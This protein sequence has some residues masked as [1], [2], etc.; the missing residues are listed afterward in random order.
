ML[1]KLVFFCYTSILWFTSSY[2]WTTKHFPCYS[3]CFVLEIVSSLSIKRIL[4]SS[5]VYDISLWKFTMPRQDLTSFL[6]VGVAIFE[7]ASIFLVRGWIPFLV[8]QIPK[9]SNSALQTLILDT[10][11]FKPASLS[12]EKIVLMCSMFPLN[13]N[14]WAFHILTQIYTASA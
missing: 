8:I 5:Q 3:L 14:Y 12:V 13:F 6:L 1:C 11:T 2:H 10:L 7:M 4:N 9:H